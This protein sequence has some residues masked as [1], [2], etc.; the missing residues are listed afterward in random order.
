LLDGLDERIVEAGDPRIQDVAKA[1]QYRQIHAAGPQPLGQVNQA[2]RDIVVAAPRIN[3]HFA[4]FG[5]LEEFGAPV[6]D[7]IKFCGFAAVPALKGGFF[8][9]IN[10]AHTSSG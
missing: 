3:Q 9:R 7:A 2:E 10:P 8:H 5:N 4:F 1:K 6:A